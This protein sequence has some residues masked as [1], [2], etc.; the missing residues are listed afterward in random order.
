MCDVVTPGLS[1]R[2]LAPPEIRWL[3]S[4]ASCN[5]LP[6]TPLINPLS[7]LAEPESYTEG[8]GHR[9]KGAIEDF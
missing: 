6:C 5:N 2:A 8:H 3:K 1:V 7:H 9:L 4:L